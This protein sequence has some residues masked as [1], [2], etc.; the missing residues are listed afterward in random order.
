[1]LVR[2]WGWK[3]MLIKLSRWS[4][5]EIRMQEEVRKTDNSSIERVTQFINFG[6]ILTNQ[7]S[8]QEE[9]ENGLSQRMP[10]IIRCIIL[11]LPVC[12]PKL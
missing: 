4:F 2:R 5:L 10:F 1:L 6:T 3:E 12:C 9:I 11:C 8:V 7:N